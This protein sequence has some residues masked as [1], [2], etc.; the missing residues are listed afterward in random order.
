MSATPTP[1]VIAATLED[2]NHCGRCG[3]PTVKSRRFHGAQL[4]SLCLDCGWVALIPQ[5]GP[6]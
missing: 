3:A 4:T 1:P 6:R 2:G 5:G